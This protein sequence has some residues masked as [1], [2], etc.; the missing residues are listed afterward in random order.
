MLV[1][2]PLLLAE[3]SILWNSAHYVT[4][5]RGAADAASAANAAYVLSHVDMTQ[6]AQEL[7][8]ALNKWLCLL[9]AQLQEPGN[10]LSED[11]AATAVLL[12]SAAA[13]RLC[14]TSGLVAHVYFYLVMRLLTLSVQAARLVLA[15]AQHQ[16]A[17]CSITTH[18]NMAAWVLAVSVFP[19]AVCCL[20]SDDCCCRVW[21]CAYSTT[22]AVAASLTETQPL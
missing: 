10:K 7:V 14:R 20:L 15:H 17:V 6:D 2:C 11:Q 13:Q 22:H 21:C 5:M 19:A 4:A 18:Y 16:P 1:A 9:Y 3:A 8:V 12:V